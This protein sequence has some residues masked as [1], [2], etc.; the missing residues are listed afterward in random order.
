MIAKNLREILF[1]DC[2]KYEEDIKGD[3]QWITEGKWGILKDV[4]LVGSKKRR[5]I[6]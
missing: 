1:V 2:D 3:I 6:E 5:D 4:P